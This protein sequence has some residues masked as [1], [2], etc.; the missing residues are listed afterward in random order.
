M[1]VIYG[2]VLSQEEIIEK[3]QLLKDSGVFSDMDTALLLKV[4]TFFVVNTDP[5]AEKDHFSVD[6][7][8]EYEK[9]WRKP[10]GP[11]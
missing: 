1:E 9:E 8:K 11:K 10:K 4:I 6:M 2:K 3:I 5:N 7:A